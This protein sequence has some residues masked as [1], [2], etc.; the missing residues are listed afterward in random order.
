MGLSLHL[1]HINLLENQWRVS[2]IINGQLLSFMNKLNMPH[3]FS[4]EE[5]IKEQLLSHLLL[6]MIVMITNNGRMYVPLISSLHQ[7]ISSSQVDV[8]DLASQW[9]KPDAIKKI[10]SQPESS[11][12]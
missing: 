8:K 9:A 2:L 7:G 11:P 6:S 10:Q 5:R 12:P 1:Y 4:W 3:Y